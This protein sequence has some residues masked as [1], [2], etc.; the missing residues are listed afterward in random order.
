MKITPTMSISDAQ[1]WRPGLR[2]LTDEDIIQWYHAVAGQL[3]PLSAMV[4]VGVWYG[5]SLLFAASELERRG[6]AHA[7]IYGVDPYGR[8]TAEGRVEVT[9]ADYRGVL[10][11]L[12]E[13]GTSA[14]LQH[15]SL[16]RCRSLEASYMFAAGSLD[17]VMID[18]DHSEAAVAIDIAAWRRRVRPG[19]LLAGH[20]YGPMFPG[21]VGVVDSIGDR[22]RH[23]HGSVWWIEV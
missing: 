14:E 23:L 16:L 1:T 13:H 11:G 8:P 3:R 20:D 2:G 5:R 21:V 12:A 6:L 4:E 19:G 22:R 18:G 15:V 10:A 7:Q 17:V 9:S